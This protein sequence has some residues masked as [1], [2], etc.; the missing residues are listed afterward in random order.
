MNYTM[1]L[2]T[3]GGWLLL[4]T[5]IAALVAVDLALERAWLA[6]LARQAVEFAFGHQKM[7]RKLYGR[8]V[9][10]QETYEVVRRAQT[11]RGYV[12]V[13]ISGRRPRPGE[14]PMDAHDEQMGW[15]LTRWGAKW[16][17]RRTPR[18]TR[19]TGRAVA[20]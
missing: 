18:P 9:R 1:D 15:A 7:R 10:D 14:R 11:M 8:C 2:E 12:W 16:K 5:T 17:M 13:R 19:E 4:I 20:P 3:V 6:L